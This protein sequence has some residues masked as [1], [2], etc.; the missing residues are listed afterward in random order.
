MKLRSVV[1]MALG[2]NTETPQ[3]Y[4]ANSNS[5]M[6]RL[7]DL[8]A[9]YSEDTFGYVFNKRYILYTYIFSFIVNGNE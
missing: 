3:A 2:A 6:L 9:L 4:K 1:S 8:I 7:G 5:D